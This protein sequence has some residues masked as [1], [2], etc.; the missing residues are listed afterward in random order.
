MEIAGTV[1]GWHSAGSKEEHTQHIMADPLTPRRRG[2]PLTE[3]GAA[4]ARLE[5]PEGVAI[6]FR[7]HPTSRSLTFHFWVS[8]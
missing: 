8:Q 3:R 1:L 7:E 6:P 2:E 4:P 5:F